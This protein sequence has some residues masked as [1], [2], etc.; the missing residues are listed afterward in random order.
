MNEPH[1]AEVTSLSFDP[2]DPSRAI[3]TSTDGALKLW[4]STLSRP[5]A[6]SEAVWRCEA[7]VSYR[8]LAIRSSSWCGDGSL[9]AAVHDTVVSV[10]DVVRVRRAALLAV[11][12][13]GRL[14]TAVWDGATDERI[15]LVGEN[16][17]AVVNLSTGLRESTH[18]RCDHTLTLIRMAA[19]AE[20]SLR[21]RWL[22]A[23]PGISDLV[24]T[25]R[26]A[27]A[28][29]VGVISAV[30]LETPRRVARLPFVAACVNSQRHGLVG[31]EPAVG[32]IVEH[33]VFLTQDGSLVRIAGDRSRSTRRGV[34]PSTTTREGMFSDLVAALPGIKPPESTAAGL[35]LKG[36]SLSGAPHVAPPASMMWDELM[37]SYTLP[38]KA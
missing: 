24:F 8:D 11:P 34:L 20:C 21:P 13:L 28:D 22:V 19:I 7:V 3:T 18:F 9:V 1:K 15:W 31:E 6:S 29:V 25:E 37:A 32:T 16:G 35:A 2:T 5:R 12:S 14:E 27:S 23:I 33:L 36:G 26:T 17:T 30:S 10:W 4:T 38:C